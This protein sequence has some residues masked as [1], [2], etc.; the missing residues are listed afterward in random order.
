MKTRVKIGL[1]N[2]ELNATTEKGFIFQDK[3]NNLQIGKYFIQKNTQI[4]IFLSVEINVL[5]PVVMICW[6]INN[7][8]HDSFDIIY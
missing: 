1:K 6:L 3:T 4:E 7:Y 5:Y 8:F 2:K